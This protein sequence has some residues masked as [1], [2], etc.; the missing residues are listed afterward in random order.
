[1]IFGGKKEPVS[2][3]NKLSILKLIYYQLLHP[4]G[5]RLLSLWDIINLHT[6]IVIF[7]ACVPL[8]IMLYATVQSF[9]TSILCMDCQQ[10]VAVCPVREAVGGD[11]LGPRGIEIA[12]R[13]GNRRIASS[14][15]I[16][17]CASCMSCVTA[18]PRGLNV[19]HDMD[20]FRAILVK[21]SGLSNINV[22]EKDGSI[23]KEKIKLFP[24][25]ATNQMFPHRVI[26]EKATR[27][28]NVYDVKPRWKEEISAQKE[29]I[30]KF[31]MNYAKIAKIEGFKIGG[32]NAK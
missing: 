1:M 21:E 29:G 10:C 26:V 12:S 3:S 32:G 9:E 27:F 19:K 14:G 7:L 4:I 13:S 8:L 28:G 20:L 16:F 25:V 17:S 30:T 11:F 2:T 24:K 23:I 18:C 31:L 5:D 22:L 15:K 6:A